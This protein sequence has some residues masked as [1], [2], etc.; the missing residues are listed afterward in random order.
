[1]AITHTSPD[2]LLT[3]QAASCANAAEHMQRLN[4]IP[5]TCVPLVLIDRSCIGAS[6][7]SCRSLDAGTALNFV[8]KGFQFCRVAGGR[9]PGRINAW[10]TMNL[11]RRPEGPP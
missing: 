4:R 11:Y 7:E 2:D 8:G 3:R 5:K 9:I 1:V 6:P 10:F